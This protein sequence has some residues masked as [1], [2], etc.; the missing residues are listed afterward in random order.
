MHISSSG[1]PISTSISMASPLWLVALFVQ[2]RDKVP[3]RNQQLP[4]FTNSKSCGSIA[5][6][7]T[8]LSILFLCQLAA[9]AFMVA[10]CPEVKILVYSFMIL[11]RSGHPC[12]RIPD[13]QP[14][15]QSQA[16]RPAEIS[17]HSPTYN[18]C[19]SCAGAYEAAIHHPNTAR[20]HL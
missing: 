19:L 7:I 5:A 13:S 4:S 14:C 2:H 9:F 20:R 10:S 6:L 3:V 1:L 18:Y 11:H 16:I 12:K 15:D 17:L 8:V